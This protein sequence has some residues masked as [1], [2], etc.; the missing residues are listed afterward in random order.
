MLIAALLPILGTV[1]DRLVPDS[2]EAAKVKSEIQGKVAE[3]EIELAKA[4]IE[5][6]KEDAKSGVGGFRWGAGWLCIVSLG[7]SWLAHPLL[8]WALIAA[9][10]GVEPPPGIDPSAQYAML[11]GMLGLAGVRSFDLLKH[12]RK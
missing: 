10:S 6:S 8:G 3:A 4:Q 9:G 5:L 11:T 12:S 7:Y 2:A 1:I